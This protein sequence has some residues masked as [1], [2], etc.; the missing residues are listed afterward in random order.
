MG[1]RPGSYVAISR[2]SGGYIIKPCLKQNK[3]KKQQQQQ[4][5]KK[6]NTTK[7]CFTGSLKQAQV[8]STVLAFPTMRMQIS[9]TKFSI[10]F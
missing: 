6:S 1:S 2:M 9:A 5:L 10:R 8:C 3:T 4:Q 7:H